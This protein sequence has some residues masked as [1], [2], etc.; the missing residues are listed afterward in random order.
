[1]SDFSYSGTGTLEV[2][3]DAVNYN[4][5]LED[6]LVAFI[7]PEKTAIDFG[8]G[9]GEFAK[10]VQARGVD[11]RCIEPDEEQRKQ[12]PFTSYA[13]LGEAEAVSRIY[14]LNVLEHI[15]EDVAALRD[16]R[17]KLNA[18]GALFLYV[19]A[20][21]CLYSEFDKAVGHYRRYRR[22]ELI[23]KLREAGF[24]VSRA[25]YVDSLG[26]VCWWVMGRLPGNKTAINPLMVKLFDR[27]IFPL[28]RLCDK[29][30]SYWFGK[31]LLIIAHKP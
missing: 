10:R 1:M 21:M 20:F 31:N 30:C 4:R 22:G 25:E 13:G 12:L 18:G 19:P 6:E 3:K 24:V 7:A 16:I 14:S 28:S 26:F 15:E 5:F 27:A 17:E 11:V 23:D 9:I 29:I 8:A 2:L